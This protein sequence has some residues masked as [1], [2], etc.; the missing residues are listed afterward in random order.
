[1]F[2]LGEIL[3]WHVLRLAAAAARA[4]QKDGGQAFSS[5]LVL[6]LS[7]KHENPEFFAMSV[8]W[9]HLF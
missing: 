2:E 8:M 6:S 4:L 3:I 1:L 9:D 5:P 7:G